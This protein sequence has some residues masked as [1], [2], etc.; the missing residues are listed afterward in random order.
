MTAVFIAWGIS[1][2]TLLAAA[3]V[4]GRFVRGQGRLGPSRLL[5]ILID[6]RGRFSLNRFQITVWTILVLSLVSG[7]YFGRL[8]GGTA[9]QAMNFDIPGELLAAL[10]ISV[11]SSAVAG[12]VKASKN[13]TRPEAVAVSNAEDPPRL[14]Q[15]LLREEGEQADK[16]IDVAKFQHFWITVFLAGAYAVL[17]GSAIRNA[18][19]VTD[20]ALP[21]FSATFLT[22]F[23]ISHAGYVAGKL[24]S[25][26]GV[27]DGPTVL[28]EQNPEEVEL[29]SRYAEKASRTRNP[30]GP[31][32]SVGA[33]T[34]PPMD[35]IPGSPEHDEDLAGDLAGDL[36]ED[37]DDLADATENDHLAEPTDNCPRPEDGP[38]DEPQDPTV[39]VTGDAPDSPQELVSV[40][41][42]TPTSQN[43]GV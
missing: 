30:A 31:G 6:D 26:T 9:E 11:G 14:T 41:A 25:P 38:Q 8:T 3:I 27:P 43:E 10:G 2:A 23:G 35:D 40:G 33:P 29:N 37:L 16:V 7:V 32:A 36:D 17:A 19:S 5:G 18:A 28:G 39:V 15:M 24:P 42:K 34:Q 13:A 4:A 12:A 1:A 21:G 20:V 22:L